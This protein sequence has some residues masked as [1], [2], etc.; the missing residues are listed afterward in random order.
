VSYGAHG[1]AYSSLT[2]GTDVYFCGGQCWGNVSGSGLKPNAEVDFY[3]TVDGNDLGLFGTST[4]DA[5]GSFSGDLFLSCGS[6]W[7]NVY[8]VATTWAGATITSNVV[9]TPCG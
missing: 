2:A 8:A 9:S 6:N 5:N 3:G 4:T 7:T 1:N